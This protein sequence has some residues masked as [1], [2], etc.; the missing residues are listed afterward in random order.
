M[1]RFAV[2][3][4]V[5]PVGHARQSHWDLMLEWGPALRTWAVASELSD[6]NDAEAESLP[7]HRLAYLDYE[8]PVSG[9][10]GSVSRWDAGHYEVESDRNG[11]LIVLVR[12]RRLSGKLS[13]C[14]Q[15]ESHFWRVSFSAAPSTG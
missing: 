1:P 6:A 12:G 3:H 2:L 9:D 7:D 11:D 4:H 5:F 8:G 15:P 14:Q 13:L 10:R